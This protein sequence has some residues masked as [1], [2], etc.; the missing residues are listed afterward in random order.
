MM[1]KVSQSA[2]MRRPYRDHQPLLNKKR[3]VSNS[4]AVVVNTENMCTITSQQRHASGTYN[5]HSG[6]VINAKY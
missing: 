5:N 6:N 2:K 1:N 3:T 4:S